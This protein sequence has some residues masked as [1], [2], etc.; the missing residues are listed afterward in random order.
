VRDVHCIN[1]TQLNNWRLP[2]HCVAA[3]IVRPWRRRA[4]IPYKQ[5]RAYAV[6]RS[7]RNKCSRTRIL[8]THSNLPNADVD[9]GNEL[10]HKEEPRLATTAPSDPIPGAENLCTCACSH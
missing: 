10:R 1:P 4:A 6:V 9:C 3:R 5:E 2:H 7:R 8:K